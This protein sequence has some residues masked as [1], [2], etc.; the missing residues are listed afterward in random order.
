MEVIASLAG[1][2]SI[3]TTRRYVEPGH[4]ELAAAFESLAAAE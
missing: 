3:E 4:E 2:E 1:H